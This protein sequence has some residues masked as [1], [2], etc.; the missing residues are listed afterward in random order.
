MGRGERE[1]TSDARIVESEELIVSRKRQ[2]FRRL[3]KVLP[4]GHAPQFKVPQQ[5]SDAMPHMMPCWAQVAGVQGGATQTLVWPG[6]PHVSQ[7]PQL[8]QLRR[9]P[10]PSPA[11]P[12]N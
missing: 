11:N 4:V 10:Q 12:R 9:P 1:P 3:H 2:A 7:G 6:P 8:P 5:P